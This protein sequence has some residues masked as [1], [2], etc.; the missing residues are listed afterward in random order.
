MRNFSIAPAALD[1]EEAARS[2]SSMGLFVWYFGTEGV[3]PEVP[4]HLILM[5]PR[6]QGLLDDIFK[7]KILAD[8]FS[9]YLHRPTATD[10]SLA[11][12]RL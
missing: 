11:P 9:L 1:D 6:Y 4:H 2:R 12:P 5:G 7:K 10:S 8:D 3:Y